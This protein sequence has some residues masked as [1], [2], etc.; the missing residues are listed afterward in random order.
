VW[1]HRRGDLAFRNLSGSRRNR[2]P[3]A[4]ELP[5][6]LLATNHFFFVFCW[7]TFSWRSVCSRSES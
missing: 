6:A 5:M 2:P 7:R 4:I 3:S 1:A